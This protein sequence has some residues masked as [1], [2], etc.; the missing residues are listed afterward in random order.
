MEGEFTHEEF[1]LA[2]RQYL[3]I[4]KKEVKEHMSMY[5]V[6]KE[7]ATLAQIKILSKRYLIQEAN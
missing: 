7:T 2:C 6:D 3:N 4:D 1:A 5:E